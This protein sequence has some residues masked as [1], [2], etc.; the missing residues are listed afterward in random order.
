MSIGE[1]AYLG[2]ALTGV[3]SFTVVVFWLAWDDRAYRRR[4]TSAPAKQSVP[5][6]AVKAA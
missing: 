3:T 5:S 1:I 6:G 2:L 4:G